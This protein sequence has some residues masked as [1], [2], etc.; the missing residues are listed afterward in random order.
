MLI[1]KSNYKAPIHLFNGH[2][3][4]IVPSIFRKIDGVDYMRE[5]VNTPDGDFLDLDWL[6]ND[7]DKLVI[8]SHGLEGSSE[9]HYIKGMAKYFHQRHWDILAWNCRSC[10]G[11]MNLRPRFYHHGATNDL[12]TVIEHGL[13]TNAYN[14]VVLIG[15]SMGG[16]LTLK[17]LGEQCEKLPDAVKGAVTFSVP[18]SLKASVRSLEK[19]SNKFYKKRFLKKLEKKIALKARMFPDKI[20]YQGFQ[21]IKSFS[22]FDNQ[23]TA[24]LHGFTDAEDFYR[25]ASAVRYLTEI[26][27]PTLIV[28]ALNDPMLERD[29]YPVE[30]AK[31]H[32]FVHLEMPEKGGHVG[33]SLLG[34]EFNWAEKRAFQFID[35]YIE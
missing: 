1:P 26:N 4:T 33:F 8:L 29:C 3:E 10:S 9:R 35:Q 22:D 34:S 12:Q 27:V 20:R 6:T 32:S 31:D 13:S 19:R 14:T 28:N 15:M 30:A 25:K 16:S 21:N 2:L 5:R 18:C 7:Y 24:P 17:Y 11:E 23:Y